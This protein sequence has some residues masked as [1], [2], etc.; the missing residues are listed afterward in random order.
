MRGWG[1]LER[2]GALPL[3]A[4]P[5]ALLGRDL[6]GWVMDGVV[7]LLAVNAVVTFAQRVRHVARA[8][9]LR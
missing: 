9:A 2:A 8:T 3:L 6:G 7:I 1:V 5:A 4:A